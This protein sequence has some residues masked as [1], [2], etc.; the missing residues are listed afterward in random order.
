MGELLFLRRREHFRVH[1]REHF[2]STIGQILPKGVDWRIGRRLRRY[3][4]DDLAFESW[5]GPVKKEKGGG[6]IKLESRITCRVRGGKTSA[7]VKALLHEGTG[8][9][10]E[11]LTRVIGQKIGVKGTYLV[12][13]AGWSR[14]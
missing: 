11:A 12:S 1:F 13:I 14:V 6:E 9:K 5:V 4:F 2:Q 8:R 10:V 7:R 3:R